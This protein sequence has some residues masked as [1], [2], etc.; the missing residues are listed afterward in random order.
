MRKRS[1][2]LPLFNGVVTVLVAAL[3]VWIQGGQI[4]AP[5]VLAVAIAGALV[6]IVVNLWSARAPEK[7]EESAPIAAQTLPTQRIHA[8]IGELRATAGSLS[9]TCAELMASAEQTA[10]L[11]QSVA[12]AAEQVSSNTT[13]VSAGAEEMTAAI[14]EISS[15]TSE[16]ARVSAEAASRAHQVDEAVQ[17]LGKS[18]TDIGTVVKSIASIAEQTNLLAL[19]ATIEAARAGDAGRG[20]AVVA[21]EVKALAR[22][23]ANATQDV[24][25][26]IAAI[27]QD[28]KTATDALAEISRLIGRINELQQTSASAVEEQSATTAEMSRN[29][30][31]TAVAAKGIAE[32]IGNVASAVR[33]GSSGAMTVHDLSAKL[34]GH[35]DDL[36]RLSGMAPG[37][38]G[39][40]ATRVA[41]GAA[42]LTWNTRFATGHPEIDAQHQ[43]LFLK[44]AALHTAMREGK[45]RQLIGELFEFLAAYTAEHFTSEEG[46]MRQA[47]YP[48]LSQHQRLHREL[49]SQV[50]AVKRRFDAG[51]PLKTMEVSDFLADWLTTHILGDDHAYVPALKSAK[52]ID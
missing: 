49:L 51:E 19:N 31:E 17:R 43:E 16:A 12:T 9:T 7:F 33:A 47:G 24:G 3:V 18:S 22:Q 29:V 20:F 26:R 34:D 2:A 28:S 1:F 40:S 25:Q 11:A 6:S 10:T 21:S 36:G 14:R 27:Q 45:G 46:I 41:V 15:T 5:A 30:A 39:G 37:A 23:T 35:A 42:T 38:K 52:I 50:G 4:T 44:V 8:E 48:E 32:A 13:T